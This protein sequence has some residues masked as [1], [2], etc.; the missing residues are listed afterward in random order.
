V[1]KANEYKFLT[2]WRV[3]ATPEQVYELIS[4]PLDYP[5]WWSAVYL[6]TEQLTP[7]DADGI[8]RRIRYHTKGWLPYTLRWESCSTE[9][10]RPH[11]IAIRASG[12]F[13]GRGIWTLEPDG[14]FVKVTFDWQLR[15]DKPLLRY[16]S[17]LL[18]PI[19][20]ANH[21]WAMARGEQSLCLELARRQAATPAERDRVAAPPGP[22]KTSGLWLSLLAFAMLLVLFALARL[23]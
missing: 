16:L 7:A 14:D 22:N 20:A 21:V 10:V 9:A 17:F 1:A 3:R 4:D 5:R 12:A 13:D 23:F 6:K 8:G 19:F 18:K 15:A 11:R 2:H